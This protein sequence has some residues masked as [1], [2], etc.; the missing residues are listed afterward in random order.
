[1]IV[2]RPGKPFNNDWHL[3][4]AT[5][6]K[7][8]VPFLDAARKH[9]VMG[10]FIPDKGLIPP[11]A[12]QMWW[13]QQGLKPGSPIRAFDYW[14]K[15]VMGWVEERNGKMVTRTRAVAP[16]NK[17]G[18]RSRPLDKGAFEYSNVTFGMQGGVQL[19]D[20]ARLYLSQQYRE[21]PKK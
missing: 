13:E 12:Q 19:I 11:K 7:T 21:Q 16:L 3:A 15:G 20:F 8:S 14:T 1:M 2:S 10:E 17:G 4:E 18:E 5:N 6:A 9:G